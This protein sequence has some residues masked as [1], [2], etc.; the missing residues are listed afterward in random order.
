M[1]SAYEA[2][3]VIRDLNSIAKVA[4]EEDEISPSLSMDYL[5]GKLQRQYDGHVEGKEASNCS[6]DPLVDERPW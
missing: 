1:C 3:P 2:D 4:Q 5:I 6:E